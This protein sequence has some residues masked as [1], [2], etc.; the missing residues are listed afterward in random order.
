MPPSVRDD[1][2]RL[3]PETGRKNAKGQFLKAI[4]STPH[5]MGELGGAHDLHV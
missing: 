5:E 3:F 4:I 2:G 1:D